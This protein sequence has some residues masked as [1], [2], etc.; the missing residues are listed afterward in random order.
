M[1]NILKKLF[2]IFNKKEKI[3]YSVILFSIFISMLME[4]LSIGMVLP[5]VSFVLNEEIAHQYLLFENILRFFNYPEKEIIILLTL[6][7]LSFVYLIKTTFVSFLIYFQSKF[8]YTTKAKISRNLFGIYLNKPYSFFLNNNS[9]FLIRNIKEECDLLVEIVLNPTFQF[10]TDLLAVIGVIAIIFIFEPYGAFFSFIIVALIIIVYVKLTKKKTK[11]ISEERIN[12]DASRIKEIQQSINNIIEVKIF[13]L[14][15]LFL[16]NYKTSNDI[17][18]RASMV[19]TI[20]QD[21]PRLWLEFIAIITMSSLVLFMIYIG[22]P[23]K[24][25]IPILSLFLVAAFKILPSLN[26]IVVSMQRLRFAVPTLKIISDQLKISLDINYKSETKKLYVNSNIKFENVDFIY[27]GKKNP[28]LK[29]INLNIPNK[30]IICVLGTSGS[31]KSTFLNLITGLIK[32]TSGKI[33]VDEKDISLNVKSW[34]NNIGY[35]PQIVSLFDDTIKNNITYSS[36]E[37]VKDQN[38]SEA[39][40]K[41][42]L[43][44]FIESLP[45]KEKTN[46]GEKGIKIS[47]GQRQRIGIARALYKDPQ[48]LIMDEAT[49]SLDIETENE[50][51][52]TLFELKNNKII[53][54]VTH[55]KNNLDKFD[56]LIELN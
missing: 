26:R 46:V 12:A 24:E 48:I 9:S 53:F 52:K 43:D 8:N 18:A 54:F 13:N 3:T 17:S 50:I 33:L 34:Q 20:F 45:L 47:G 15:K 4:M 23:I 7:L 51:L 11:I 39:I 27:P 40:K 28:V 21:M 29:K 25:I 41:S 49:N 2:N 56:Q 44:K 14:E 22:K 55:K 42:V 35:V 19:Q 31:G 10:L 32:P 5:M 1:L 36:E 30:G 38:Y 37:A 16:N 6:F